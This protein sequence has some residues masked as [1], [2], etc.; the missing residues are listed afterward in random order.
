MTLIEAGESTIDGFRIT[1][2]T[3]SVLP[4][5]GDLGGGI[6]I[7][8]GAPTIANNL[9]EGN[10]TRSGTPGDSDPIGG[11]IFSD[12]ANVS[13]LA[14]VIRGNTSGRGAGV[15]ITG[16]SPK[17]IGNTVADN[18][19]VADHGGGLYIAA[20]DAQIEGNLIIGNEIG[21]DAGLR[22]GWRHPRVQR[23]QHRR[24]VVQRDDRQLRAVR[25]QWPVRR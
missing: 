12:G 25:G 10:D 20:T 7:Q 9:I 14:N 17:V 24:A 8:G 1:G 2:G 23:G 15:A 19:G 3:Q 5:Y 4:E 16:G 21:R 13:I 18:V 6:Y 11:G 22:L